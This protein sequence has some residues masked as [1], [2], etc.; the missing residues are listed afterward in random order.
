[1]QKRILSFSGFWLDLRKFIE[2][3]RKNRKM[4]NQF[5]GFLVSKS[6]TST[7][8]GHNFD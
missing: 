4:P 3:F 7:K 6:T 8:H 2:N 5:F 1:M